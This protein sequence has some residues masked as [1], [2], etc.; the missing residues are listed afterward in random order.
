MS[1]SHDAGKGDASRVINII[2]YSQRNDEINWPWRHR[3]MDREARA[4]MDVRLKGRKIK[5]CVESEFP[6]NMY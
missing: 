3:K 2:R 5:P 6:P 4:R 1:G